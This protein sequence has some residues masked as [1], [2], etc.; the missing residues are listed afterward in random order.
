MVLSSAP[1]LSVHF[2]YL[3]VAFFP[4]S[5]SLRSLS[6]SRAARY[7]TGRSCRSLKSPSDLAS[8]KAHRNPLRCL[9]EAHRSSFPLPGVS[10]LHNKAMASPSLT[11]TGFVI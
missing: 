4:V 5:S 2:L 6:P 7:Q 9:R 8:S 10:R 1:S 3:Y 11:Q